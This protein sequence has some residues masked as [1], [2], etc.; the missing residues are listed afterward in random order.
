[1]RFLSRGLPKDGEPG[2]EDRGYYAVIDMS[3]DVVNE[4]S[5]KIAGAAG[6]GILNAGMMLART[7][8]RAGLYAFAS[9]EYPSLIRGGHNH[10]DVRI[11]E[12][13]LLAHTKH[14]DL[15]V[16]LNKDSIE[17][18]TQKLSQNGAVIY[19]GDELPE[20]PV[21]RDDVHY[22]PMPLAKMALEAGGPIM[23]N[24]IAMGASL[25]LLDFPLDV[26]FGVIRDNFGTK[27]GEAIVNANI[28]AAQKGADYIRKNFTNGFRWR[29]KPVRAE[30]RLFLSGHE[31]LSI[32]AIKAGCSFFSAYPMTPA[33]SILH[34]MASQERAFGMVV[35]HTEDEIAA[36]NMAIGA[37][38]AGVRA[39]TGTSGGGFALMSEG[40]GLA[41]QTETPIVVVVSQR[42]GPATGMATH[43][44]QGDLRYV[45]H[46]STDEFPRIVMAP[47]D[48]TE[49]YQM[50][51]EAFNLAERHQLP[52]LILTDKYLGESFATVAPLPQRLSVD[53]GKT[54]LSGEVHDY[55]RYKL[56]PDAVSPRTV[57]GVKGGEHVASSYEHD[58][59]GFEREEPETRI[60]MHRKRWQKLAAVA[61][62]LP[63]PAVEGAGDVL[64]IG[65]GSTKG[66]IQ[67]AR[68]ELAA[69]GV[70][71]AFLQVRYLSPFPAE[72][73][74]RALAG[75]KRTVLVENNMTAQLGSLIREH[76]LTDV[77]CKVL[78]YDGRPFDPEDIAAAVRH[79]LD[80]AKPVGERYT[81]EHTGAK[82]VGRAV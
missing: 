58:E 16:A 1:M 62:E 81:V 66:T 42:P 36:I 44:G 57:P 19:D 20:L 47:G 54:V 5:W 15:L 73:V 21:K 82:A 25:A 40:F 11:T 78:K 80:P 31:A 51:F 76:C 71:T 50:G 28:A 13:P 29:L 49:C 53:R 52:V 38:Y 72:A 69:A 74:K 48:A 56:T 68:R 14:V 23:R 63:Q 60:A 9:A 41:A 67:E 59:H 45:L 64:L 12:R 55:L 65:W 35:K 6:H 32:G 34:T 37:S 39:M 3:V 4:F 22:Y 79:I 30:K 10:L 24:V 61:K 7:A 26:F 17:F 77:D 18:H 43:S 70:K 2:R 27:K 46:A 8:V 75:A 33:S